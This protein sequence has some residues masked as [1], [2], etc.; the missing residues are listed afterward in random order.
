[1]LIHEIGD[2]G[3]NLPLPLCQVGARDDTLCVGAVGTC[4]GWACA[5]WAC[6]AWTCGVR[7]A[8]SAIGLRWGVDGLRGVMRAGG[9]GSVGISGEIDAAHS[10]PLVHCQAYRLFP[11]KANKC[12][13]ALACLRTDVR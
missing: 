4:A 5:G 10:R 3:K 1:M 2:G 11:K 12:S 9:H 13:K 7:R 8:R 6:V